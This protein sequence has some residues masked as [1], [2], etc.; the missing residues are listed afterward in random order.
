MAGY[1]RLSNRERILRA[2]AGDVVRRHAELTRGGRDAAIARM[3]DNEENNISQMA[4]S[5]VAASGKH[6]QTYGGRSW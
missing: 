5:S 6:R 2:L 3:V 4:A 1:L